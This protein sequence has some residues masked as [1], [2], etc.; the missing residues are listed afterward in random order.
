MLKKLNRLVLLVLAG[1][2]LYSCAPTKNAAYFKKFRTDKNLNTPD[3]A[4]SVDRDTSYLIK[5]GDELY[6][7]V[8]SG[9]DE[10]NHFN[11]TGGAAASL[12]LD[13]MTFVVDPSGHIRFPYINQVK[14]QGLSTKML[15]NILEQRLTEFIY[16]PSVSV[17]VV[18]SRVTVLGDV[19]APGVYMFNRNSLS[20]YE[21]IAHAGDL[22]PYGN[23]K[24]VL[25]V[26][27]EGDRVVK[28]YVDLTNDQL[29]T[30]PWYEIQSNDIIYVEPL[31]R[32]SFGM[33][34]FSIFDFVG[35]VTSTYLVYTIIDGLSN[36]GTE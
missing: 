18:N 6:I 26:R 16:M 3:Q 30:S 25:I 19:N 22:T 27:Q 34:T 9:N 29:M 32:R 14:A 13:L 12:G 24:N 4:Y 8:T 31:R 21:V 1:I 15:T 17:R 2:F 11:Q 33:E 28:K 36:N 20:I 7:A 23:R 5:A 10:P 35:L